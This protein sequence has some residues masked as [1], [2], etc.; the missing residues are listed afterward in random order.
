MDH[1]IID[2]RRLN[3]IKKSYAKRTMYS[4]FDIVKNL[5]ILV[6]IILV[7]KF[8]THHPFTS[9]I[10]FVIGAWQLFALFYYSKEFIAN[11]KEYCYCRDE[12]YK[13]EKRLEMD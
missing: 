3:R 2:L 5:V 6:A 7:E 13:I 11:L 10:Y 12:I 4:I 1:D 8:T 9:A